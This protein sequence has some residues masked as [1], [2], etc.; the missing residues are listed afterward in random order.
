MGLKVTFLT[1][2]TAIIY[3]LTT[4][5]NLKINLP[6]IIPL[7]LITIATLEQRDIDLLTSLA[8]PLVNQHVILDPSFLPMQGVEFVQEAPPSLV[9]LQPQNGRLVRL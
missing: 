3:F 6:L 7:L 9:V 4:Y 5:A 8:I 2:L 1:L